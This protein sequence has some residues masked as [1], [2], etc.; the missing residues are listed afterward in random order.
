MKKLYLITITMILA[1]S[2]SFAADFVPTIMTL[3]SPAEIEY[4]F[5]GNELAIPFT[6]SGTPAAVWLVI[7]TKG[8]AADISAVQ[9]G[10]LGWHYVNKID[11]TV[12]VSDRYS[13]DP[14]ET[15]IVW[16]G[17]DQ[18]GNA[19]AAGTYDYYLW[20]Y[21]DVTERQLA[22]DFIP[23]GF[24]WESTFSYI[25][26]LGE[27]GLP[28]SQ[29]LIVGSR[30]WHLNTDTDPDGTLFP[31]LNHGNH[32][33]WVIGGDPKDVNHL[34]NTVCAIY[35]KGGYADKIDADFGLGGP[36]FDPTDYNTFYHCSVNVPAKTNTMLKWQFITDGDAV[37]D[38]DW[39][40]WEELT[41][42]DSGEMIGMWSQKP[43]CYTDREYIYVNSPGLHQKELEWNRLRCVSFDGEVIFDKAMS[44]WFYPDDP[45]PHAYING[46]FHHMHSRV[47]NYWVIAS[48]TSCMHELVNTGRIVDDPDV[49]SEDYILWQNSN[50]DYYMDSAYDPALEP[51][52]YCLADDKQTSMRRDSVAIDGNG[53]TL[54]GVAYLGLSSFGVSTQD[55]TGIGYM[56]FADDTIADDAIVK[57][58][59]QLCD[60]G[61]SYDGLYWCG[62]LVEGMVAQGGDGTPEQRTANFVA[63]DSSHGTI[64]NEPGQTAV[65][66]DAQSAFAV[67]QNSPNPFNP[68]T[69]I[70]FTISEAGNATVDI[71]NVA[72]QR[73]ET[74]V[75]DFMDAG[76]HS[77]VWDASGFS[78][79]VYF[80]TVKSGDFSRTM[81]MTLLK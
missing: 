24:D 79:G 80:Y 2:L 12:Y 14:G 9:N 18:D 44:E 20:A 30:S 41:W 77:V 4:Q 10:Y 37:L 25:Y 38:E 32:F 19:A 71:Y 64:T 66:E 28:L 26:E 58:G 78:N 75:N 42:E 40:G 59:G 3:T 46:S 17:K 50:G 43:S 61:S 56:A 8:M 81:K 36:V 60:S 21:D 16:S 73:I 76:K 52:W 29:P 55:G 70:S 45:N 6:V 63:S 23:M 74:L 13:R 11:T 27:D 53:F 68:T 69:S 34:Q 22:C 35:A 39:L 7:N 47:P 5:D 57:P 33:K 62:A 49:D 15:T 51:A 54:I 72:G 48:H 31:Y 65:E 67:D 1:S